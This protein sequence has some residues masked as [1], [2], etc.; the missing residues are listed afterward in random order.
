M[1]DVFMCD[2]IDLIHLIMHLYIDHFFVLFL[3]LAV[4]V[5]HP[6]AAVKQLD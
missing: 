4:F 3:V 5:V 2:F 6:T 1:Y